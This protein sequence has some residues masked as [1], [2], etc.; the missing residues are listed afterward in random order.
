MLDLCQRPELVAEVTLQPLRRF[1][2]DAAILFS[3]ITVP[4]LALGVEFEL[5]P[6]IGPV[7]GERREALPVESVNIQPLVDEQLHFVADAVRLLLRELR[8]PLLGFAGAPFTLATYLVEGRPSRDHR[9]T[10]RLMYSE[11]EKWHALMQGLAELTFSH[12]ALQVRA[13]V[14]AV[15]VFDSWVGVLSADTYRKFV[16]PHMQ[17]LMQ[18]L[19]GLE[20]PVILFGTQMAHLYSCISELKPEVYGVDHSVSLDDLSRGVFSDTVLQGNLDPA[21]LFG[22]SQ[23]IRESVRR[24]L[25]AGS[26]ARSHIMNLGHGILPETPIDGVQ[27]MIEAVKSWEAHD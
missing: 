23:L 17:V 20:V 27:V 13:G 24:V 1:D 9:R 12:L 2:L 6:G 21:V 8:V 22:P 11:P 26:L 15:Q 19:R 7:L 3:D 16:L 5:A 4:F 18:R 25:V 10:R 14:H